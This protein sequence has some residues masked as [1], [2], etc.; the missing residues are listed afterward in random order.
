MRLTLAFFV[1]FSLSLTGGDQVFAENNVQQEEAF[2]V[3]LPNGFFISKKSPVEDFDIHTIE[4][5]GKPYVM[6][7]VGNQPSFPMKKRLL[8]SEEGIVFSSDSVKIYSVF[9][10]GNLA[11]R[12]ILIKIKNDQWPQYIHAWTVFQTQESVPLAEKILFSIKTK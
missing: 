4:K 5:N 10:S 11:S 7:Y 12:E 6:I 2:S 3:V 9:V 1:V 8:R